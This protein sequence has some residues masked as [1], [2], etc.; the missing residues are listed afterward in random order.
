MKALVGDMEEKFADSQGDLAADSHA[1]VAE[2]ARLVPSEA[3]SEEWPADASAASAEAS[4]RNIPEVVEQFARE[5][6]SAPRRGM[7]RLRR[8]ES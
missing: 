3:I 5:P 1:S 6:V 4:V 7:R 8:V 2:A